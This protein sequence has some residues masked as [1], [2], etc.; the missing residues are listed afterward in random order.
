MGG[1]SNHP[2]VF[3]RQRLHHWPPQS[4]PVVTLYMVICWPLGRGAWR[5]ARI[6]LGPKP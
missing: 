6:A 3:E 4:D 5:V 1:E 2:V